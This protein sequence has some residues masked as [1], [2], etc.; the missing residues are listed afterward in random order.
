M[1]KTELPKQ[2]LLLE[3][4]SGT[5]QHAAY[6]PAYLPHI[7]WQT[8]DVAAHLPSIQAWL[9]EA[10]LE[11]TLSPLLLDVMQADWG[12]SHVDAVFSANTSHIMSWREV[13]AFFD[14]VG[15]ILQTGGIF[16][17]YGPFNEQGQYSSESNAR[18]DQM[19]RQR[20]PDSGLRDFSDLNALAQKAD[21]VFHHNHVMPVNNQMLIWHKK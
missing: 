17:L 4:G 1:L 20:D 7:R 15:Q 3:I 18:F 16:C 12:V 8:S 10:E 11:N 13:Q 5:G 9:D 21:L 14:G 2:G 19:L 6:M